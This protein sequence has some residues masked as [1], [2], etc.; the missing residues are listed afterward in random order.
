MFW[1]P[2]VTVETGAFRRAVG[3]FPT[4]VVI[5]TSV[6]GDDHVALTAN[7]FTSVSLDPPLVLVCVEKIA[8]FREVVLEAGVWGVSVLAGDQ[9]EV[10]QAYAR[11]GRPT[12]D[13]FHPWTHSLGVQTGCVLLDDALATLECRT[14]SVADGGDHVVLIGEVLSVATPRSQAEALVYFRGRYRS[15]P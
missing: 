11:R 14:I 1:K 9:V 7:S 5:V 10:S 15:L 8:R 6:R 13:Q 3:L 2:E 12:P 4:G